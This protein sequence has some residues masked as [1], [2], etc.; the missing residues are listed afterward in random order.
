MERY[1]YDHSMSITFNVCGIA[2]V[3]QYAGAGI[4]D[5]VSIGNIGSFGPDLRAFYPQPKIH[6]FEFDD[7]CHVSEFGP[8]ESIAKR[9]INLADNILAR[10]ED[11]KVLYHCA[12]GISR[13]TASL[14]I[15]LVRGGMTYQQAYDSILAVR[16]VLSPNILLIKRA[17]ILMNQGGKMIDFIASFR[18]DAQEWVEVNGHTF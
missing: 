12:A 9:L 13:S 17:D 10:Q 6:R 2:E 16:G 5:I 3:P 1:S 4:T 15:L 7:I 18:P 14:F 11:T 8:T